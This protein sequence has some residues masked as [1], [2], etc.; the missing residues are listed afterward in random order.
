ML[1]IGLYLSSPFLWLGLGLFLILL[2]L[3]VPGAYLLWIGLA[4]LMVALP[5]SL[6]NTP[7]IYVLLILFAL[8]MGVSVWIG[9]KIQARK[10]SVANQLNQGLKAYLGQTAIVAASQQETNGP[11]RI[12]LA[13]TSYP[14]YCNE[15]VN[16]GDSVCIISVE[17][18]IIK[19][20]KPSSMTP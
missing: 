8:F 3:L 18:G 16:P 11:I 20:V 13:G 15:E 5:A 9:I 14:A 2:D 12:R 19:V 10:S 1:S 6:I 7:S 4:A 17:D